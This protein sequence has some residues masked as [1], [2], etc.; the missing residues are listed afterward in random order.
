VTASGQIV[1]QPVWQ[2]CPVGT[3][4][5]ALFSDDLACDVRDEYRAHIEDGL[6]AEQASAAILTKYAA[7]ASDPEMTVT[8]WV[9]L[10]VTQ[11]RLG[12]LQDSVRDR[13]VQ[14]IDAG[15]DLARWE[16]ENPRLAPR[17][18]AALARA[19]EQLG[20][21]Q[22]QPRRLRPLRTY[23]TSLRPGQVLA[24][25]GTTGTVVLL[26]VVCIETSRWSTGPVLKVLDYDGNRVP[27]PWRLRG[28]LDR[29]QPY[30]HTIKLPP[31]NCTTFYAIRVRASDH[32][33][34]DAG[35][36]IIGEIPDRPVGHPLWKKM[37][38]GWD[39]LAEQLDRYAQ[40]AKK[41]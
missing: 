16:S 41:Q 24:R 34:N 32:D 10:A 35:F 28:L 17:R 29:P 33:F 38:C 14:L 23:P 36:S 15:G 37:T 40:E 30:L 6:T 8:F 26:R 2:S 31:W 13:A 7:E 5:P 11:S 18:A 4:G 9:A 39:S 27:R 1:R 20:G 3:T 22:P 12:R 21:E 25:T 19:R